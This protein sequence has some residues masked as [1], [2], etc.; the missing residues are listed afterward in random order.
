MKNAPEVG[1]VSNFWGALQ[2]TVGEASASMLLGARKA[3]KAKRQ[4]KK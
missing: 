4:A 3:A 1:L 2:S